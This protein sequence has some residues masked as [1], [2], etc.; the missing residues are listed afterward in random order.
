[1][2]QEE[3]KPILE[4]IEPWMDE[5]EIKGLNHVQ[6][7]RN[8]I[9]EASKAKEGMM[10]PAEN[11]R[12]LNWMTLYYEKASGRA[13][14]AKAMRDEYFSSTLTTYPDL[15]VSRAKAMAEGSEFGRKRT[16]YKNQAEGYLEMINTLKKN[17]AYYEGTARGQY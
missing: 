17:V 2:E 7:I 12:A 1:M 3:P 11:Q 5:E 13:A 4:G 6:Q 14:K 15:T 9:A 16:Y 10:T 8:A